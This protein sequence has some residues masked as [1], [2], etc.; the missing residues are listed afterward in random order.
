MEL[1]SILIVDDDPR[2]LEMFSLFLR[3]LPYPTH[4]ARSSKEALTFLEEQPPALIVLDVA[5]PEISGLEVLRT[6]RS[7]PQYNGTKVIILTAI[8]NAVSKADAALAD[9]VFSKPISLTQLVQTIQ[10][11]LAAPH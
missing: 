9:G 3:D 8:P 5:M 4:T 2:Q 6:I 10:D 11:L 1:P 7:N